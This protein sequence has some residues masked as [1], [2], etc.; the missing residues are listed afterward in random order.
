MK[1]IIDKISSYNLLNYLF[2][3]IIFVIL[4]RKFTAIDL[5]I[6][7]DFLGMFLYYFIGLV[8]SR[9]GSLFLE[10]LF[11]KIKL[12][13]LSEYQDF[14]EASKKDEKIE[15]FSEINNSYRTITSL[16]F[17]LALALFYDKYLS[18]YLANYD[19]DISLITIGLLALFMFSYKKQTSY[20][21]KRIEKSKS[22]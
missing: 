16:F 20:I 5:V 18:E 4:L 9:I 21:N 12:V 6:E 7:N 15:L 2:P 13:S 10:P 22:S 17:C 3:G 14:I 11:K 19:I 1:E 8:I